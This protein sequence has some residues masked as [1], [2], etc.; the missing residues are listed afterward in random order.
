MIA[1][2]VLF[3]LV[4]VEVIFLVIERTRAV[5]VR[6]SLRLTWLI[7]GAVFLA[8]MVSP[9][10]DWRSSWLG[11]A[12]ILSVQSVYSLVVLLGKDKVHRGLPKR[13]KVGMSVLR[14]FLYLILVAPLF[15]FPG[16]KHMQV[17]GPYA[18]GTETYTW[19]DVSRDETFTPE[20]DQRKVTVQFWYPEQADGTYPLVVFSHGAFGY[21]MSNHSTFMELASNGYVV[22]SIDHPYHSF[23]TRQDDGNR[24][25]VD[26]DF[27]QTAMAVENGQIEGLQLYELERSW[28]A[29]RTGD[30]NFVLDTILENVHA[31]PTEGVFTH[32]ADDSIGVMGH[33]MGGA[34]AAAIG[35][36]RSEVDAVVVLDGTMMG[37][38]IGY[39]DGVEQFE[40]QM[41]PKTILNVFNEDHAK[42][43]EELGDSYS[44]TYMHNRSDLSHQVV[45]MG[46]GHL[47]FTDLPLVSPVL[48]NLLGTGTVDAGYCMD[49]T[50]S[51]V[52]EF[53]DQ[54]LKGKGPTVAR[55]RIF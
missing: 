50:N 29:L 26:M 5:S 22:C 12:C 47:N 27:L 18:V 46:S 53:F 7:L 38:T 21:R 13:R 4:A 17:T 40:L 2:V 36:E 48:A 51:L 43:A 31:E 1:L 52:L 41:Y 11:L 15:L 44:N 55:E 14:I 19:T 6:R 49:L 28:M 45:V 34:T 37:E 8:S 54:T 42:Q 10:L 3:V 39:S 25:I 33:S 35:R 9:L 24:V 16:S 20:A 32:I 30:M 23:M